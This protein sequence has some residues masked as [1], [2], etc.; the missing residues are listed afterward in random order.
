MRNF[1]IDNKNMLHYILTFIFNFQA[2]GNEMKSPNSP[3]YKK[4]ENLKHAILDT[5]PKATPQRLNECAEKLRRVLMDPNQSP[6][7]EIFTELE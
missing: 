5:T 2:Q 4:K 1:F 6:V 7:M 3:A